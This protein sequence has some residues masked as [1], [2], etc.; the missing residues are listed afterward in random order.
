[1]HPH[2]LHLEVREDAGDRDLLDPL[3]RR[4]AAQVTEE[5]RRQEV[6]AD[7]WVGVAACG[8]SADF[9][10]LVL[11]CIETKFCK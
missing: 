4:E 1:M 10:G 6:R 9:T 2:E 3:E 8:K 7:L 5:L 11:G